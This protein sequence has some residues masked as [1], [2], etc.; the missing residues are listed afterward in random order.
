MSYP[1][2]VAFL[3]QAGTVLASYSSLAPSRHTRRHSRAEFALE[4]PAGALARS[5]V[6]VGDRLRWENIAS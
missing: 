5:S 6:Q 4:L 3:D 1:I 2:D